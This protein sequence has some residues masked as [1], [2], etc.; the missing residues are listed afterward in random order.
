MAQKATGKTLDIDMLRALAESKGY[1]LYKLSKMYGRNRNYFNNHEMGRKEFKVRKPEYEFLMDVLNGRPYD[2]P[3]LVEKAVLVYWAKMKH[4][5][6]SAICKE[7]ERSVSYF[8][9]KD[10]KPFLLYAGEVK[11]I[12]TMLGVSVDQ[13]GMS[14]DEIKQ[15]DNSN[16]YVTDL[17]Y[18]ADTMKEDKNPLADYSDEE[19]LAEIK[20]RM[21]E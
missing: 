5:H 1:P 3:M 18:L 16:P 19:L 13:L 15:E 7:I 6:I 17:E 11:I 2:E 9:N 4:V 21:E 8:S 14:I 10:E 12:R 20:R